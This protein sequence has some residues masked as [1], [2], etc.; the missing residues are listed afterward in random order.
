MKNRERVVFFDALNVVSCIAV[1]GMHVNGTAVNT[2]SKSG[3]WLFSMFIDC[4]C[5]FAVPIFFML[6]GAT[7]IDYRK[8]YDTGTFIRKRL[9]RTMVPFICWSIIAILW[10]IL[11][12]RCLTWEDVNS[13]VKLINVIFNVKAFN[14]YYFFIDLFAIYLCIP[15]LGMISAE[16]RIG[17]K[18]AY[19]YLIIYAFLSISFLPVVLGQFGI[20]WN[21]S[22]QNPLTGGYLIYVLLG[23]CLS[24]VELNKKNRY[25]IYML[26]LIGFIVHYGMTTL[27]SYRDGAINFTFRGYLNFPTVL[28]AIAV[29]V[30]FRYVQWDKHEKLVHVVSRLSGVSF[31]VYLIHKY[32]IYVICYLLQIDG[33]SIAWRII[34]TMTVYVLSVV[35]VMCIQK[36]PLLKKLIP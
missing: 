16:K 30:A 24:K 19:T 3:N 9:K 8:R 20:E 32:P 28:Y 25:V 13:P 17:K 22:L 27:L 26:G 29:F 11:A 35:G 33:F 34:G 2:F 31:G 10:C 15:F 23:Y 4:L 7:L 1:V 21:S 12:L 14:I 5:Y 18:G 36:I 6:S